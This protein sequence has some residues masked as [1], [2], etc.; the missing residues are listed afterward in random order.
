[1]HLPEAADG[2]MHSVRELRA[3]Q[4]TEDAGSGGRGQ[5]HVQVLE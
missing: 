5:T 2:V 1:M 4:Q 3:C